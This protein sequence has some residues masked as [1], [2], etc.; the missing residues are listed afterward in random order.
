MD[1]SQFDTRQKAEEGV[2]VPLEIDGEV[3][4]SDLDGEP[5]TFKIKGIS[6]EA[7]QKAILDA[8]KAKQNTPKEV[9]A[10]DMKL[11]RL[12]V[13]GWSENF[14]FEGEKLPFN[15]KNLER[16]FSVPIVRAA[17]LAKVFETENFMNG[18]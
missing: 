5:I 18:S 12:A 10:A 16:V 6:D 2:D 13:L 7:I 14:L 17:V 1:L 15:K 11:A 8:R 9:K 3:Q 4:Y